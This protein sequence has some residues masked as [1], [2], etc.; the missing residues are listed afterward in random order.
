MHQQ[1][2]A[3]FSIFSSAPEGMFIEKID[4]I[5][6]VK[7]YRDLFDRRLFLKVKE[8]SGGFHTLFFAWSTCLLYTSD[9]A[10]E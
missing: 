8:G 6:R 5:E 9:A 3:R 4:A 10:D 2:I 1:I 7:P